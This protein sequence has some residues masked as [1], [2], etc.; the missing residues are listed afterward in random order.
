MEVEKPA[1]DWEPVTVITETQEI[2]VEVQPGVMKAV[3]VSVPQVTI[4]EMVTVT[5]TMTESVTVEPDAIDVFTPKE[6]QIDYDRTP[7]H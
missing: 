4:N 2:E 5:E 1:D 3:P 7:A 6:F